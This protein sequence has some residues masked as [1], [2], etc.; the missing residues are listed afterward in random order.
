VPSQTYKAGTRIACVLDESFNST[1]AKYGD[2]FKL[3]IVDPSHPAL[4]GGHITG[5]VT[6]VDQPSGLNKAKVVFFLTEIHLA[7]GA[8]KPITAYVVSKRVTPYNPMAAQ[9]ARQQMMAAPPM[10]QGVL[11]PGPIAWQAKIGGSGPV[12]IS[13]RPN[14]TVGGQIYAVNTHEPIIVPAGQPVTIE[15]QQNLTIP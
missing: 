2:K 12:Q 6:E 5:W 10:P 4:Q 7:N 9:A 15:L 13:N 11:T 8:K 14:G 3:R 1:T